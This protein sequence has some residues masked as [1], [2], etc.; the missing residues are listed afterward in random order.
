MI[1]FNNAKEQEWTLNQRKIVTLGNDIYGEVKEHN[2]KQWLDIRRW[3]KADDQVWYRTKNGLTLTIN[4][5]HDVLTKAL[6]LLHNER[7]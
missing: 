2:G 1:V 7:Q 4:D 3:F 5:M 6:E